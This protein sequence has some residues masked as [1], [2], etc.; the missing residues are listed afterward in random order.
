MTTNGHGTPWH[1]HERREKD[2]KA[3]VDKLLAD[4]TQRL[5]DETDNLTTYTSRLA[6]FTLLLF[7]A[8]FGQIWLFVWQLCRKSFKVSQE[9]LILTHHPKLRV[10][11]ITITQNW[12]AGQPSS[13]FREGQELI[14][15]FYISNV[16]GTLAKIVESLCLVHQ[17]KK[18][19][20]L[21]RPYE[22]MKANNPV[23]SM[24]TLQPGEATQA[25]FGGKLGGHCHGDFGLRPLW[26]SSS[27]GNEENQLQRV[28]VP[29]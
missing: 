24:T 29:S 25:K 22:E 15:H 28:P 5:A 12:V 27:Q 17:T 13:L 8:A 23:P 9:T 26:R 10:R 2:E 7:C 3:A 18:G 11:N 4:Q 16:G 14:G 1:G 6:F 20:P 19:L 21:N